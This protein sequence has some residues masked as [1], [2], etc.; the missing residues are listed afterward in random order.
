MALFSFYY[1]QPHYMPAVKR[2]KEG[3]R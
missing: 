2:L 1:L 3:S